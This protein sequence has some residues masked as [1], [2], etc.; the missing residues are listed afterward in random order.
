MR[1]TRTASN[2]RQTS[3]DF[4]IGGGEMG[5][6]MRAMDWSKTAL[7]P[8]TAWPQSLRT[9][10]SICLSSAFPI[11]VLWGP[12]L[13]MIYNDDYRPML[14]RKHPHALGQ[15]MPECWHE[16]WDIIG[17]MLE[18]VLHRGEATR[19]EDL[20]LLLESNGYPEERYFSFSYSPIRD[21]SGKVGGVLTPVKETT[22]KVIGERRLRTL[23]DLASRTSEGRNVEAVCRL[24]AEVLAENDRSIP[25]AL[26]Y[27]ASSD[28]RMA[29]LVGHSGIEPGSVISPIE[30]TLNAADAQSPWPIRRVLESVRVEPVD[31]S[32]H[33]GQLPTGGWSVPPT[34]A[35]VLPIS[36][37][38]IDQAGTVLVAAVNPHKVLDEAYMRFLD[39]VT[40]QIGS[41]TADALAYEEERKRA[42]ALAEIDRAKTAFFSNVSHEF[43]TPLSLILGPLEDLLSQ[44]DE[45]TAKGKEMLGMAH[46][47]GM[48]LLKLVNTL[49][50]FSRIE[51]G[52]VEASYEPTDL[53]AV[54]AD[55]A[56]NFRSACEK[57]GLRLTV[58]CA[59]LAEPVF[60]DPDLWEKIVLNLIS[61]A[62]KYTLEGEINV[63][64]DTRNGEAILSVQDTGCGIAENELPRLFERFHRVEG[65]RGRTHEGTGIGL[66]LV[67]ELVKLHG[68][69]VRVESVQGVG[70][71]FIVSLPL[72]TAHLPPDRIRA[73]SALAPVTV[74]ARPYVEEALRWLPDE[75][76]AGIPDEAVDLAL[77]T[78]QP[79]SPLRFSRADQRATILLAD[80]NA[81]MR[82][83]VRRLLGA[84][85]DVRA[86]ADG[87]AVLKSFEQ[88]GPPDLLLSDVMMP[89]LDGFGL[90]RAIRSNPSTSDVPVILLSARAGEEASIEGLVVGA[91]DYLIKPF[92]GRELLA[93]V[94]ANLEMARLRIQHRRAEQTART[95][96]ERLRAALAASG[97]GTYRWNVRAGT[98]ESDAALDGLFGFPGD[99]GTRTVDEF[100]ARVHADDQAAVVEAVNCCTREGADFEMEFRVVL[101]DGT[102]RWLYDRG[103]MFFD[104]QGKPDYVAGACVDITDRKRNETVLRELNDMLENKVVERT[105][106]LEIE[107]AER[108]RAEAALQQA[109]RLEL[110][111]QVT[112]GVAHDFNN[113]LMIVGGNLE[114]LK[115]RQATPDRVIPRIEQAIARGESLT[116]QL[117]SFSRRQALQPKVLDLSVIKSDLVELLR[118]S[119][120]GDIEM[121]TDVDDDVWP[122][123]VDPGELELALLNLA[124]N[125]RD[126]M[127]RGGVLTLRIQNE[128]ING[129]G[130]T[131]LSGDFVRVSVTDNGNGIEPD[132]LERVFEPFFT[133]KEVGKGTGLGLSQVH[134]FT[135][136]AG[137]KAIVQSKV[138]AGTTVSLLLPRCKAP[139]LPMELETAAQVA[140]FTAARVLLAED[141]DEV[142]E[143]T[144]GMLEALGYQVVRVASGMEALE[145]IENNREIDLVITDIVMPGRTNGIDVARSI[146]ERHPAIPVILTTGYSAAAREANQDGFPILS[147]PYPTSKLQHFVADALHKGR[148]HPKFR[149]K[150]QCERDAGERG[151]ASGRNAASDST[152]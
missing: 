16:I 140:N 85:Y 94:A 134:G 34:L 81:D 82:D 102:V 126:A 133:T 141:N 1:K 112:G 130:P 75:T 152:G 80:D 145:H 23:R 52:R 91:D 60:V 38:G 66:A 47:N 122:I 76:G 146:R 37:P 148:P 63:R 7:G 68:G 71:T 77:L 108:Q 101:P 95:A 109:Q 43:R 96:D 41:A 86:V 62:F 111:G 127:P 124:V 33:S 9:S 143:V 92:S 128:R 150:K 138:G 18:G 31:L 135:I 121:V 48:R 26:L 132:I 151:V 11:L 58:E 28:G 2:K 15:R 30:I 99:G 65:V 3:D 12:D 42:E 44:P 6:L 149:L 100:V 32:I 59:S 137:G 110:M 83:Y 35:M 105:R 53:A 98:A 72:G 69:K 84:S 93:R 78:E 119:L 17:P 56:S 79:A 36:V 4:L 131:S 90:L 67:Q 20:L 27:R 117:L 73:A 103:K 25:F 8:T 50:D 46:R 147:K 55:L 21:E 113:L 13:V 61:N 24:A 144:T 116:R 74:V 49:L 123:E 118:A 114:L 51:A 97:T 88:D 10:V 40:A 115:S 64:L 19:A 89:G 5:A 139:L 70:S 57:A 104:A 142:A 129:F 14:G 39:Q 120:R 22:E 125:A 136:Q 106:A 45:T 107:M 54:T 87:N 29:R